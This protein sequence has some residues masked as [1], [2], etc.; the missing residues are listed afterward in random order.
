[1][2]LRRMF[3]LLAIAIHCTTLVAEEPR[4]WTA[5]AGGFKIEATLVDVLDGKVLL[6]K[7]DGTSVDLPLEKLSLGDIRY[8]DQVMRQAE[9]AVNRVVGDKAR[10]PTEPAPSTTDDPEPSD[11]ESIAAA[12]PPNSNA[13]ALTAPNRSDWQLHPDPGIRSQIDAADKLSIP[14]S[15]RFGN[16]ETVVPAVASPF[17][18]IYHQTS[19]SMLV[20]HDIR[21]GR[22]VGQIDFERNIGHL[23]H[24]SLSP[25]GKT[26]A[27]YTFGID[28]T[29]KVASLGALNSVTDIRLGKKISSI[30]CLEFI[31]PDRL[32][33]GDATDNTLSVWDITNREKLYDVAVPIALTRQHITI[34]HG[35]NY[36][37]IGSRGNDPIQFY[38]LRNGAMAGTL[39]LPTTDADSTFKPTIES[40][41]FSLDGNEVAAI[42]SGAK[43][44]GLAVWGVTDGKL[45][46]HRSFDQPLHS[47][48]SGSGY[49][50]PTLQYLPTDRGWL[51]FGRAVID[52]DA[53]GV[54]WIE[55]DMPGFAASRAQRLVL[56]DGRVV[57]LRGSSGTANLSAQPLPWN[58]IEEGTKIVASG[59]MSEDA[60]LPD[61]SKPKLTPSQAPAFVPA[62]QWTA[63]EPAAEKRNIQPGPI[64]LAV[65]PIILRDLS[66]ASATDTVRALVVAPSLAK[67]GTLE[68][69][70]QVTEALC[71]DLDS[72]KQIGTLNTNYPG[73]FVD[74]TSNGKWALTRTGRLRDR[75]DVF[76]IDSAKHIGGFRPISP[77]DKTSMVAWSAFNPDDSLITLNHAGLMVL[78]DVPSFT[79]KAMVR[80]DLLRRDRFVP[81][82]CWISPSRRLLVVTS[83]GKLH[84][85]DSR[86]LDPLGTLQP[87]P[88]MRG[89]WQ[90]QA[91]SFT[92]T[93]TKLAA[94]LKSDAATSIAIWDFASGELNA[95]YPIE[96]PRQELTWVDDRYV[97]SHG[98]SL[99]RRNI[100]FANPTNEHAV[101]DLIDSTNGYLVWRYVIP[102]GN[103]VRRGPDQRIW[104]TS[105]T[106]TGQAGTLKGVE[107]PS[108]ATKYA[109]S[110]L[111]PPK[112]LVQRGS[113]ISLDVKFQSPDNP[114]GI[115]LITDAIVADVTRNLDNRGIEVKPRMGLVLSVVVQE[116]PTDRNLMFRLLVTGQQITVRETRVDCHLTLKD[117]SG[118]VLWKR[119]QAFFNEADRMIESIPGGT[120]AA[121]HLRRKQ[122]KQ[123]LQWFSDAG[124]P[125]TIYEPHEANGLGESL[126]GPNG[127]TEIKVY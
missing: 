76:E 89:A 98:I 28:A 64:S 121:E 5:R 41:A 122:W 99:V 1:M 46:H 87:P 119:S 53:S 71:F 26:V 113:Q 107:L 104:Y 85:I 35:G 84:V 95:E 103:L 73:E 90:V 118:K 30:N 50:G 17:V 55:P 126:L 51:L 54:A 22:K 108:Q 116:H 38:D 123:V 13:P 88:S 52:R 7:A 33:V 8:I 45:F 97:L 34:T 15:S 80:F 40:I 96:L 81:T 39:E 75:L 2:I 67:A 77:D 11:D 21:T 109:V 47:L 14:T 43:S 31:A 105:A 3:V 93:G 60:K 36:I 10:K 16:L 63:V 127:E 78:W 29:I 62:Q 37:A 106:A 57:A 25:D 32:L 20:C 59:G 9:A 124:L 44:A 24:K 68:N 111:P 18:A 6:Q 19:P 42:Y 48:F 115:D 86:T 101:A 117:I 100:R 92:P 82:Q 23:Q 110:Q 102:S 61:L 83:S 112:T 27:W 49:Q 12:L 72:A 94:Q 58:E 74:F 114:A 66:F 125:E 69:G 56:S 4:T 79:S 120:S 91:L 65:N 70:F